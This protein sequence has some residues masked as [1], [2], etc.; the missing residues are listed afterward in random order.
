MK[1]LIPSTRAD[2]ISFGGSERCIDA[3]C[4]CCCYSKLNQNHLEKNLGLG[5][6]LDRFFTIFEFSRQKTT[7]HRC[8]RREKYSL[9]RSTRRDA[10]NDMRFVTSDHSLIALK[11]LN[12]DCART[13]IDRKSIFEKRIIVTLTDDV[14]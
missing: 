4:C 13:Q 11:A 7:F 2:S 10:S 12:T 3:L 14:R 6:I 5:P 1:Y 8:S 9:T